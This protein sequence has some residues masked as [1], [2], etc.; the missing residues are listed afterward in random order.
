MSSEIRSNRG[1]KATTPKMKDLAKENN[2]KQ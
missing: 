2:K 1:T